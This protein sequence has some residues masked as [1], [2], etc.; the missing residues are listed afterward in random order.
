MLNMKQ[1]QRAPTTIIDPVD[2]LHRENPG[3]LILYS[4]EEIKLEDGTGIFF[5]AAAL[6]HPNAVSQELKRNYRYTQAN[7]GIYVYRNGRLLLGGDTLGLFAKDFHFNAFRAELEYTSAADEHV[8]V[9]VAKSHVT[10]SPEVFSRLQELASVAI[11]TAETLWR[12]KDVLTQEDIKGVFDESNSLIA[13]RHRLI[14]DLAKKRRQKQAMAES[15]EPDKNVISAGKVAPKVR[16]DIPYLRPQESLPEDVL[17]RPIFDPAVQS[18]VVDINLAH[19]FSKAVF[20][21]SPGEGKRTIPR[22]ATTAVQ[23]LMYVLGHVEHMLNDEPENRELLEQFRRY[24]S[25]N[26]RALLAD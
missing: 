25:M 12:E 23:Q 6:P 10:L 22:R 16:E 7:Q 24:A 18:V 8:L 11:K 26:L 17:Y 1:S 4:R 5:S 15:T 9:D 2:P 19:P 3:T 13:S 20:S 21:V 14:I